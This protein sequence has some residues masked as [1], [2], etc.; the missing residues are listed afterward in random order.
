MNVDE[1]RGYGQAARVDFTRAAFFYRSDV[2]DGV[3]INRDVGGEGCA[4]AA[5]DHFAI[6][7]HQVVR[8]ESTPVAAV[9]PGERLKN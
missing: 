3:A 2:G 5:V 7:N 1:A 6:S 9:S 8:H 4:P